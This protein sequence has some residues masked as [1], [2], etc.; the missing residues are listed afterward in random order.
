MRY[1]H[2]R[3]RKNTIDEFKYINF[4]EMYGIHGWVI[5]HIC[6]EIDQMYMLTLAYQ[7]M[8]KWCIVFPFDCC[9]IEPSK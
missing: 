5:N 3:K 1:V 7:N 8:R 2:A 4:K 6:K 9:L